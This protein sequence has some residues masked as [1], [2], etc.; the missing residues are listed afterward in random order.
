MSTTR[1]RPPVDDLVASIV[2]LFDDSAHQTFEI[3]VGHTDD[4]DGNGL[5]DRS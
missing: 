2:N 1:N 4:H 5:R 3:R